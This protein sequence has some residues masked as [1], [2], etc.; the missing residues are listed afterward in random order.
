V[1]P[2]AAGIVAGPALRTAWRASARR[3]LDQ[4]VDPDRRVVGFTVGD[5]ADLAA[6]SGG[7]LPDL[8]AGELRRAG[9]VRI[10]GFRRSADAA[11]RTARIEELSALGRPML[12]GATLALLL[13]LVVSPV[14]RATAVRCG[15]AVLGAAAF[16]LAAELIARTI[17]LSGAASGPDRDLAAA[18]W[19]ELLGGLRTDALVLLAAGAAVAVVARLVGR[20]PPPSRPAYPLG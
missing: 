7:P 5:V 18:V 11:A 1:E 12:V 13:A 16:V 9:D 4:L 8:V 3:G 14:R 10:F 20:T 15:L 2:R 17:T 6:S 19:D